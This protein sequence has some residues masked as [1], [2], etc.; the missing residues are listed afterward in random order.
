MRTIQKT[1]LGLTILG[2]TSLIAADGAGLYKKCQ[3]CHGVDGEKVALGK[4]KVI[5]GWD[6]NKT[7]AALN[8]YKD[9][10]YGGTMKTIMKGQVIAL[11]D[12]QIKALAEF[13]SKK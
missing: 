11:N 9:G 12:E 4:S 5:K 8:G 3:G 7:I 13:I 1:L 6:T 2:A 10:T